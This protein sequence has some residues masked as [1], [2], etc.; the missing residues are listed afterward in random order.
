MDLKVDKSKTLLSWGLTVTLGWILTI[1]LGF[2]GYGVK[3]V[4]LT[5]TVLMII[6][7]AATG[8]LYHKGNSNKVFNF[9]AVAVTLL[10]VQNMLAPSSIALYSYFHLWIVA[11]ALGFHYTS[12]KLPPPSEKIYRY[13]ALGSIAALGLTIYRPFLAPIAAVLVQ[14][15]PMLYDYVKV[16][17]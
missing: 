3:E 11:G 7:V 14:G 10:M 2:T 16:H 13:G 4:M 9:W 8:I 15:V 6:P 5:W 1:L 17:R 12:Q